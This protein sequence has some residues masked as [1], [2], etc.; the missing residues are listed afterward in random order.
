M[1][2]LYLYTVNTAEKQ[3]RVKAGGCKLQVAGHCFTIAE[4]TQNFTNANIRPKI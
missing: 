2:Y 4:T 1:Q 3:T